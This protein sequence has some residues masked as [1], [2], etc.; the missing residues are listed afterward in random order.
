MLASKGLT[1]LTRISSY[2]IV[3]HVATIVGLHYMLG[4]VL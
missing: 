4:G 2:V 1:T 3:I